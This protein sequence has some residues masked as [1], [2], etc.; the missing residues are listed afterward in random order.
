MAPQS[1]GHSSVKPLCHWTESCAVSFVFAL[2]LPSEHRGQVVAGQAVGRGGGLTCLPFWAA[3][4]DTEKSSLADGIGS[5]DGVGGSRAGGWDLG[6]GELPP[7]RA[8]PRCHAATLRDSSLAGLAVGGDS[9]HRGRAALVGRA[10]ALSPA[11]PWAQGAQQ[12]VDC[13]QGRPT[14]VPCCSLCICGSRNSPSGWRCA[15]TLTTEPPVRKLISSALYAG[16][17]AGPSFPPLIPWCHAHSGQETPQSSA[18]VV[19]RLLHG[20]SPLC[21]PSPGYTLPRLHPRLSV[22]SPQLGGGLL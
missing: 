21:R 2:A 7:T 11:Q 14:S 15:L 5:E 20:L 1:S 19:L 4:A 13:S 9:Q 10:P 12:P 22:M 6:L 16:P 18:P 3:R 8:L 17:Q